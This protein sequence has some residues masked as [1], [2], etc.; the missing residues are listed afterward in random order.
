MAKSINSRDKMY[1]FLLAVTINSTRDKT[2]C[3]FRRDI[4][5]IEITKICWYFWFYCIATHANFNPKQLTHS[6]V[7]DGNTMIYSTN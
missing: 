1:K 5:N 6:M 3:L 2:P 7:M 4:I